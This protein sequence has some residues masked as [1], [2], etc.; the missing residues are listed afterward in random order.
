MEL[1]FETRQAE[2]YRET[3]HQVRRIQESTESVVPDTE[4]DI[5]RIAAVQTS[6][7]LKSKDLTGR[8]V[9][10][11]GEV[12][13]DLI[14]IGE[15][16]DNVSIVRTVKPFAVEYEIPELSQETQP[17]VALSIQAA[18]AR[19][20][21]P[22]KVSV[23]FEIASELSCY[24][25]ES[26]D[27]ETQLPAEGSAGLYARRESRELTLPN[28]ATEKIFAIHEQFVL[29]VGKPKPGKIATARAELT[30]SDCQLIGS[31]AVIKGSAALS[32]SYLSDEVDYP[33]RADFTIPFSQ[34]V[35]IGAEQMAFSTVRPELTAA[36]YDL[37]DTIG[38]EKALD[39]E[40]HV[41][42]QVVS[43]GRQS[44][45]TIEDVYSNAMPC[46][47]QQRSEHFTVA[48]AAKRRSLM[49]EE[50]LHVMDDCTDVLGVFASLTR[51]AL[52]QGKFSAAVTLDVLYRTDSGQLS[53]VKRT[54]AL[55]DEGGEPA[56][57]LLAAR[58]EELTIRPD[59]QFVDV[60]LTLALDSVTAEEVQLQ[61]LV[62]VT[63]D[64]EQRYD[65]AAYPS[66]SLVRA[67]GESLWELAKAYHSSEEQI[68]KLNPGEDYAGR[69]LLIRRTP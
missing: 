17:Q 45:Q 40:L 68:R 47:A 26:L 59:A 67:R 3:Y 5:N 7:F 55:A 38:G 61:R 27:V 9:S 69:M 15:G 28:A 65:P 53:S 54:I 63:L 32:V 34:I 51:P 22:R 1:T 36:Y 52:E 20:V 49:A 33:V 41:L 19:I 56:E 31:K 58:I 57:Q 21:N 23:S 30:V 11:S 10:I 48:A 25:R 46:T 24:A 2:V 6:V 29:P 62:G 60:H 44:L 14:C 4:E 43:Y 12:S 66:V 64:E 50:R 37:T 13:A 39:A 8:G 35:E 18:D 42:L 16:Q